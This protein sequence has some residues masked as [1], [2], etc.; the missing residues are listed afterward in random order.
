MNMTTKSVHLWRT[1]ESWLTNPGFAHL[2]GSL[3]Y[4]LM[5]FLLSGASLFGMPLPVASAYMAT[6]PNPVFALAGLLGSTM[7]YLY[8]W[9]IS[10]GMQHLALGVLIFATTCT[11]GTT[12]LRKAKWFMPVVV[13][14]MAA[15]VGILF[16]LQTAFSVEAALHYILFVSVSGGMVFVLHMARI[17]QKSG[18]S[19]IFLGCLVAGCGGI[20]F[21]DGLSLGHLMAFFLLGGALG[22]TVA[23]PLGAILGLALDCASGATFVYTALFVAVAVGCQIPQLRR[24]PVAQLFFLVSTTSMAIFGESTVFALVP[25]SVVAVAL[26]WLVP[27][28]YFEGWGNQRD[29][30]TAQEQLDGMAHVFHEISCQLQEEIPLESSVSLSDIFDLAASEVCGTCPLWSQCWKQ[31]GSDTYRLFRSAAPVMI[32]RGG[33]VKEDFPDR[34][35]DQCSDFPR[36]LSHINTG[37]EG[38]SARKQYQSRLK[39]ARIAVAD[40]YGFL[41]DYCQTYGESIGMEKREKQRYHPDIAV[42]SMKKVGSDTSGDRGTAFYCNDH[43][44][45]VLLCDGMGSGQQAAEE[46]ELAIATLRG[47][48]QAGL[49]PM[50]GLEMLNDFYV[51]R[52]TGCFSTVDLLWIDLSS[53][54]AVLYKWGTAPTYCKG[55]TTY[56]VGETAPPPGVGVGEKHQPQT[57]KMTMEQGQSVILLTD[58]ILGDGMDRLIGGWR[59]CPPKELATAILEEAKSLAEDDM[60]AVVVTLRHRSSDF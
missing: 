11:V 34:F 50:Y 5:G 17:R 26:G 56:K 19:L 4:L 35:A 30:V 24:R 32:Q 46:A 36:L 7:G 48:L 2:M 44:Y 40:Q 59:V 55:S 57:V 13:S 21:V 25:A 53:G 9:G 51:L 58:G 42:K 47:L 28:A 38:V 45:C 23:L 39:E 6:A 10:G 3:R 33:A 43:D 41:A 20:F 37:I 54:E 29:I 22:T 16:L 52:G 15:V 8:F 18:Y 60:T 49:P 27:V 1:V 14:C 12:E 31:K